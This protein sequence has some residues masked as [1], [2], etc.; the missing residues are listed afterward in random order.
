MN[1][2]TPILAALALIVI[3]LFGVLI[4]FAAKSSYLDV[5]P[6][7]PISKRRRIILGI[8]IV[9]F[10]GGL[11][12]LIS[13]GIKASSESIDMVSSAPPVSLVG[14]TFR[15]GD[16]NPRVVDLRTASET[17]IPVWPNEALEFSD[18]WIYTPKGSNTSEVLIEFYTN[19]TFIGKIE[20]FPVEVGIK[21]LPT[22]FIEENF[23]YQ[24]IQGNYWRVENSWKK[25]DIVLINYDKA[26]NK[27]TVSEFPIRLNPESTSWLIAPPDVSITSFAYTVNDG[28]ETWVDIHAALVDGLSLQV[29]DKFRIT[30]I[31]YRAE[32]A[33]PDQS[34]GI[35]ASLLDVRDSYIGN[36]G[37]TLAQ[38]GTYALSGFDKPFEWVTREDARALSIRFSR[39]DGTVL[40]YMEIPL[41]K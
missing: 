41:K 30:Q 17:G 21:K 16:W 33:A 40:D 4:G 36:P 13:E 7:M 2:P 1:L 28:P 26:G 38:A 8:G 5:Q 22:V 34:F 37:G 15:T 31:L 10:V 6:D 35:E 25:I 39:I 14:I 19:E 23:K 9:I 29:G 20:R 24:E 11:G 18:L 3:G 32:L 12:W 27:L